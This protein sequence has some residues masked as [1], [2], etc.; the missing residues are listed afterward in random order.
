MPSLISLFS[1]WNVAKHNEQRWTF[2]LQ[3]NWFLAICNSSYV[4][5]FVIHQK[6]CFT[7]NIKH[8]HWCQTFSLPYGLLW[9]VASILQMCSWVPFFLINHSFLFC[10]GGVSHARRFDTWSS[11]FRLS[12]YKTPKTAWQKWLNIR[13]ELD[14]IF[15]TSAQKWCKC[16]SCGFSQLIHTRRN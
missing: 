5:G 3:Q 1:D 16:Y 2:T 7:E 8:I 4:S 15:W 13:S 12:R 10:L 9:L 11:L 6:L 14:Q